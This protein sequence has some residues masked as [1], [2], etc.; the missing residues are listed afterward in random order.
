MNKQLY[1]QSGGITT[2]DII[3]ENGRHIPYTEHEELLK[4]F[5]RNSYVKE[6]HSGGFGIT[7]LSNFS[8]NVEKSPYAVFRRD[9]FASKVNRILLK[10][11]FVSNSLKVFKCDDDR[12]FNLNT[13]REIIDEVGIQNNIVEET[14]SYLEPI[15]MPIVFAGFYEVSDAIPFIKLLVDSG[16]SDDSPTIER[17]Y[18]QLLSLDIETSKLLKINIIAMEYADGFEDLFMWNGRRDVPNDISVLNYR[19][20]TKLY[21]VALFE[22]INL[23]LAGFVNG[24]HHF[25]NLLLSET[26][27]GYFMPTASTNNWCKNKRCFIIDW[28]RAKKLTTREKSELTTLW[29]NFILSSHPKTNQ[30]NK[31][32]KYIYDLGCNYE[33][34]NY[35]KFTDFPG[36]L[37]FYDWILTIINNRGNNPKIKYDII[38]LYNTR[39]NAMRIAHNEVV[40]L[41]TTYK[42]NYN[43]LPIEEQNKIEKRIIDNIKEQR[44]TKQTLDLIVRSLNKI[45][46]PRIQEP[47]TAPVTAPEPVQELIPSSGSPIAEI[48][49]TF[50]DEGNY[51]TMNLVGLLLLTG[52]LGYF[53]MTGNMI[54]GILE[55][56]N[57]ELIIMALKSLNIG[58]FT[59]NKLKLKVEKNEEYNYKLTIK[60]PQ[61][62]FVSE[63]N[64]LK[65][66]QLIPYNPFALHNNNM[67]IAMAVGGYKKNKNKS[68]KNK[69]KSRK[70]KNK[71]RKNKNKR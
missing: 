56:V 17:I 38:D 14:I 18:N 67:P 48:T 43:S 30:L 64:T 41:M 2:T 71:S 27:N 58:F 51:D 52:G 25:G 11:S 39:N 34:N 10:L 24:D 15:T 37:Y 19:N 61:S 8:G 4:Y 35:Y 32:V 70:N 53:I 68:R 59:F 63:T 12:Y 33:G 60:K 7:I 57:Y 29:N 66:K 1:K 54:G 5:I 45:D 13:E 22:L 55:D 47:A 42:L 46:I 9:K 44:L 26:Y 20:L 16:D 49:K 31:V 28:G 36:D 6:G 50:R 23:G 21:S 65:Q 40:Q 69:N 3:D 62:N